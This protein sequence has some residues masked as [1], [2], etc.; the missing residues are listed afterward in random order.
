MRKEEERERDAN[1]RG[2]VRRDVKSEMMM[3]GRDAERG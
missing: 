3:Q 2:G 1:L